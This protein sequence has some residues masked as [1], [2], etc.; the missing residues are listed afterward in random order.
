MTP[1]QQVLEVHPRATC[2]N[3]CDAFRVWENR[4]KDARPLGEGGSAKAA[5][6][7]AA[8]RLTPAKI[9]RANRNRFS[10][11]DEQFGRLR[12]SGRSVDPK[13]AVAR[14]EGCTRAEWYRFCRELCGKLNTETP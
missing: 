10:F 5:W 9:E 6:Q 12:D 7:N 3:C 11:D 13:T 8:Y 14:P 2:T 4:S 1:K